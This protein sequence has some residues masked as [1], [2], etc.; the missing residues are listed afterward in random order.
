MELVLYYGFVIR[1]RMLLRGIFEYE[2]KVVAALLAVVVPP[3]DKLVSNCEHTPPNTRT[4]SIMNI[5]TLKK[6]SSPQQ[7]CFPQLILL[8]P[9]ASVDPSFLSFSSGFHTQ[10][11]QRQVL[12]VLNLSDRQ[13]RLHQVL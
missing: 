5:S 6:K 9:F 11:A 1:F 2:G 12:I 13:S 10:S 7:D 3:S 4:T 8:L